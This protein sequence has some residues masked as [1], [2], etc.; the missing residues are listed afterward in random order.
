M[1][2]FLRTIGVH[3]DLSVA[4]QIKAGRATGTDMEERH[5]EFLAKLIAMVDK[6]DIMI[7]DPQSLVHQKVYDALPEE[8]RGIVDFALLNLVD[9]VRRIEDYFRNTATPNASPELQ[10]MIE[11]L[12]QMKSRLEEKHGDVLKI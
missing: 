12:W 4:D 3:K 9:Q 10:T 7:G 6:G 5:K 8:S 2:Q 1:G 11:Y